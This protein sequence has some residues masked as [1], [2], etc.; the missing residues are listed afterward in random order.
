MSISQTLNLQPG[1]QI[2][3][4]P[5]SY[6]YI[7]PANQQKMHQ[8]NIL[9]CEFAQNELKIWYESFLRLSV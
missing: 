3:V 7:I 9:H 8:L 4:R 2:S 5:N 6:L 1:A